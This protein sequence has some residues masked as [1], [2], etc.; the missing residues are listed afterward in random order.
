MGLIVLTDPGVNRVAF[1]KKFCLLK[2]ALSL[3]YILMTFFEVLIMRLPPDAH[4][5]APP[6]RTG[7][8]TIHEAHT[9]ARPTLCSTPSF[10]SYHPG[11]SYEAI[12]I[13]P[14]N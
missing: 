4:P 11:A 12:V 14:E 3:W 9:R 7:P 6:K 1:G 8:V 2:R 10:N 13:S 5:R